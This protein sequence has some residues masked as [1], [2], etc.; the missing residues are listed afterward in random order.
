MIKCKYIFIGNFIG[1][2]LTPT[3]AIL[4]MGVG[5]GVSL[6][7]TLKKLGKLVDKHVHSIHYNSQKVIKI[8]YIHLYMCMCRLSRD[9]S[10]GSWPIMPENIYRRIFHRKLGEKSIGSYVALHRLQHLLRH[11]QKRCVLLS[12]VPE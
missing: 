4:L 5:K 7:N 2:F 12:H 11:L 6:V 1:V 3:L 8:K 9:S 10:Y